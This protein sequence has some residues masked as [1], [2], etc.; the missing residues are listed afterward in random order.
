[1]KLLLRLFRVLLSAPFRRRLDILDESAVGFR[2]WPNDL[3]LNF[4]MNNGRYLTVMDI[5]RLDLV[6][7]VGLLRAMMRRRWMPVVATVIIRYRKSL[8]PFQ[9]YRLATRV[10]CWD[11]KWIYLE[12]RFEIGGEVAAIAYV[13]GLFRAGPR[14]LRSREILQALDQEQRSPPMPSIIEA[15]RLAEGLTGEKPRRV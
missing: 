4:H 13:K 8:L 11:E 9:H 1:M 10:V 5:G 7:R 2:V 6:A 14:T 12:Q 15:L 3:D